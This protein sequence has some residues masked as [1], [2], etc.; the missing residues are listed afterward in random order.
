MESV[1]RMSRQML[2]QRDQTSF[3]G[4]GAHEHD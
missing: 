1:N 3:A 2:G 4:G